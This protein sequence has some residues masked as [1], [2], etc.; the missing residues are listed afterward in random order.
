MITIDKH[1]SQTPTS[2]DRSSKM[3]PG[4]FGRYGECPTRYLHF[5]VGHLSFN[6]AQGRSGEIQQDEEAEAED[7]L[8]KTTLKQKMLIAK[9]APQRLARE[10]QATHSGS[11]EMRNPFIHQPPSMACRPGPAQGYLLPGNVGTPSRTVPHI[12]LL[13][14]GKWNTNR[15]QRCLTPCLASKMAPTKAPVLKI[16]NNDGTM[17]KIGKHG[18]Q[19]PTRT[20][21]GGRKVTSS[22]FGK[23]MESLIQCLH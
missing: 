2:T 12:N 22:K 17:M 16:Y 15:V 7:D 23:H 19:T 13:S 20:G 9:G 18:L 14:S 8:H 11:Q 5:L 3:S 21:L 1:G 10:P 4:M 6:G